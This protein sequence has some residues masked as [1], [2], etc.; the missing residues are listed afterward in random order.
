MKWQLKKLLNGGESTLG[1]QSTGPRGGSFGPFTFTASASASFSG[2]T[3]VLTPPDIIQINNCNLNYSL[4][5]TL[6]V[7]LNDILPSFCIPQ[8]CIPIPFFGDLCTPKIC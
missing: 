3:V 5:L 1:N 7:D 8:I 2:G 6:T 4:N